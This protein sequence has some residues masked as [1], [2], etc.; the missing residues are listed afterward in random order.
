MSAEKV[1]ATVFCDSQVIIVI[2]YMKRHETIIGAYYAA[3][4]F[5]LVP[6]PSYSPGVALRGFFLLPNPH[7]Y[8]AFLR[9]SQVLKKHEKE[10]AF[11]GYLAWW[12][13]IF[14]N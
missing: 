12:E 1:M 5:K 4:G 6:H 2:D 11:V 3:L 9:N 7:F 10:R 14:I 8:K 13:D